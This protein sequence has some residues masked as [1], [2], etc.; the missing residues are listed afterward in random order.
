MRKSLKLFEIKIVYIDETVKMKYG[1]IYK[2]G[3]I[4]EKRV[5]RSK[6]SES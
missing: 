4:H 5:W 1:K 2:R 3:E 6:E